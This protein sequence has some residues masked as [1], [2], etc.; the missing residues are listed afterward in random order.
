MKSFDLG[1]FIVIVIMCAIAK[2]IE[3]IYFPMALDI[4]YDFNITKQYMQKAASIYFMG[5]VIGVIIFGFLSDIIGRKICT[6]IGFCILILGILILSNSHEFEYFLIGK[7]LQGI[8][9]SISSILTQSISRDVLSGKDLSKMYADTAKGMVPIYCLGPILG[10]QFASL[11][12]WRDT[13]YFIIVFLLISMLVAKYLL[14]ET[15]NVNNINLNENE[16]I[17]HNKLRNSLKY[18]LSRLT[19]NQF[20]EKLKIFYISAT[21]MLKDPNILLRGLII[22]L[23]GSTTFGIMYESPFFYMNIL[24]LKPDQY[25]ILYVLNGLSFLI[26]GTVTAN[27]LKKHDAMQIIKIIVKIELLL[28]AIFCFGL[29]YLKNIEFLSINLIIVF[30]VLMQFTITSCATI[31]SN[32]TMSSAFTTKDNIGISTSILVI[33]YYSIISFIIYL[34]SN[35]SILNIMSMPIIVLI[36]VTS[37]FFVFN[38]SFNKGKIK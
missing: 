35:Y 15:L 1:S 33:Y 24:K 7:C 21:N 13:S 17:L 16:I 20:I 37:K 5:F 9:A 27:M 36:L 29:F 11:I 18:N 3:D 26:S 12:G 10:G 31:I 14:P 25:S 32:N 6:L 4:V 22:G 8:G 30:A 38:I 23:C 2:F 19:K 28:A 34:I